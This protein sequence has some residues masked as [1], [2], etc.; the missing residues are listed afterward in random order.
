MIH[1]R[2]QTYRS[3]EGGFITPVLLPQSR[4]IFR[5]AHLKP[6]TEVWQRAGKSLHPKMHIEA[7][8]WDV[9]SDTPR[10]LHH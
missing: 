10:Y 8:E 4:R 5:N 6:N 2:A 1:G 7:T 3:K 9:V